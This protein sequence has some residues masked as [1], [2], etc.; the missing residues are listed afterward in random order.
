MYLV[1]ILAMI[2]GTRVFNEEYLMNFKP[3]YKKV[4]E[5]IYFVLDKKRISASI[6]VLSLL[7]IPIVFIV[8]LAGIVFAFNLPMPFALWLLLTVAVIVEETAK[9]AGIA[10]LVKN[11]LV[12]SWQRVL[13]LSIISA[14]SFFLGEKLLLYLSM[15]VISESIFTTALFSS[16]L[17]WLPLLAHIVATSTVSLLTYRLS[18]KY[19]LFALIMGSAI[20]LIYNLSIIGTIK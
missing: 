18:T 13:I 1:F 15:S 8:Q 2:T 4:S 6:F 19:Y 10:V 9:S 16:K 12:S 3:L 17:L 14:L 11:R 20:H 7:L 5:A